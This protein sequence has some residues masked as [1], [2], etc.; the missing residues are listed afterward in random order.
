M[1]N[2][3]KKLTVPKSNE[4]KQVDAVR[5]WYSLEMQIWWRDHQEKDREREKEESEKAER[6]KVR[7]AALSKLSKEEKEA[8]GLK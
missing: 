2:W 7:E 8:L 3:L 4:T 5:L 1:F 6:N